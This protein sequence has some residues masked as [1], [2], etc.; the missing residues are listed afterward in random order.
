MRK[1]GDNRNILMRGLAYMASF[2][3]LFPY[4]VGLFHHHHHDDDYLHFHHQPTICDVEHH[5]ACSICSFEI[6]PVSH[7]ENIVE[8]DPILNHKLIYFTSYLFPGYQDT[9][10]NF[11]P[12]RAPPAIII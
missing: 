1:T 5:K 10:L 6:S 8:A 7:A 12:L 9:S 4:S 3:L 11:I 2:L